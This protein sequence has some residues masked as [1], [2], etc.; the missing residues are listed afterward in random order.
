MTVEEMKHCIMA[1]IHIPFFNIE[2]P[3]KLFNISLCQ[4]LH[5]IAGHME[6]VHVTHKSSSIAF[7]NVNHQPVLVVIFFD[8]MCLDVVCTKISYFF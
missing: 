2:N 1:C 8:A 7:Y 4:H 6:D 3:L 5:T